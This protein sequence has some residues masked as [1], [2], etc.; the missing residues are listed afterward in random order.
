MTSRTSFGHVGL[1]VAT[2]YAF[3]LIAGCGSLPG[4]GDDI[5]TTTGAI[6]GGTS[7]TAGE[8]PWQVRIVYAGSTA[9]GG[10]LL[11]P[12]W[13][14]TAGH[15]TFDGS[16]NPKPW[17]Q[18]SIVLGDHNQTVTEGVEQVRTL[19]TGYV[20]PSYGITDESTKAHYDFAL[21]KLASPVTYDARTTPI[22]PA[23]GDDATGTSIASGW[24]G[25]D[26]FDPNQQ[27]PAI[28][29]KASLPIVSNA[30]CTA[31]PMHRDLYPDELCAGEGDG[32]PGTCFG[33]S[34]GPLVLLRESGRY[35]LIGVT[36]WGGLVCEQYSVFGRVGTAADWIRRHVVDPAQV[37]SRSAL[38]L[39]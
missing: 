32:S 7:A 11:G 2:L 9:C 30:T 19:A 20:H 35:E 38:M 24:G 39:L 8:F 27:N 5:A 33:D 14:L 18:F 25:T 28:L 10:S 22:R 4:D 12:D 37:A 13:V 31:A 21:L 3:A 29:R 17:A 6:V 15:C 1:P 36:S 16:G 34:G 23:V 26:G